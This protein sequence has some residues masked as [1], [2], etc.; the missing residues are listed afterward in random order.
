F[1]PVFRSKKSILVGRN[2]SDVTKSKL[3]DHQLP[4]RIPGHRPR[5]PA[6]KKSIVKKARKG[7]KTKPPEKTRQL[8][9]AVVHDHQLRSRFQTKALTIGSVTG[10]IVDMGLDR[11]KAEILLRQLQAAVLQSV[12]RHGHF[13][14]HP[15]PDPDGVSEID[16]FFSMNTSGQYCDFPKAKLATGF[17]VLS[18]TA[19]L[20]IFHARDDTKKIVQDILC[21]L[22]QEDRTMNKKKRTELETF[23]FKN[24][25]VEYV[26]DHIGRFLERL[27][28]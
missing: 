6:A 15:N 5:P 13:E 7:K 26:R 11:Q 17:V 14:G 12:L 22:G 1:R 21:E 27:F 20:D 24:A 10:R 28:G 19:L 2:Y 8:R 25:A 9:S 16:H 18:E 4:P 23:R 3:H